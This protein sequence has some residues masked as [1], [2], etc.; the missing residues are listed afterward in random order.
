MNLTYFP[1]IYFSTL[2]NTVKLANQYCLMLT[3]NLDVRGSFIKYM[4]IV[5]ITH[6]HISKLTSKFLC[7]GHFSILL[8]LIFLSTISVIKC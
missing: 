4:A 6:I 1:D 5:F 2:F 3:L 8:L 7:F